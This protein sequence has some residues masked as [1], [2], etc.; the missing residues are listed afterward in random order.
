MFP[1]MVY[2]LFHCKYK[3]S[4]LYVEI[5]NRLVCCLLMTAQI[6]SHYGKSMND[7]LARCDIKSYLPNDRS[8]I[9]PPTPIPYTVVKTRGIKKEQTVLGGGWRGGGDF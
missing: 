9:K 1:K 3:G 2:I 8:L 6:I 4:E 5:E 7:L